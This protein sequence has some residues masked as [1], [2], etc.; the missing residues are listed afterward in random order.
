VKLNELNLNQMFGDYGAAAMKQAGN[1]LTGKAE[2]NLSVQ[3]KIAKDKFISDFIGRA[4]T[5]LNSAI[6]SGLV[7]PNIKADAAGAVEPQQDATPE[8]SADTTPQQPATST[9]PKTPAEIQKEKLAAAAKVAQDQ[10]ANSPAP[11]KPSAPT[12]P[13]SPEQTR[14]EKQ[15]AA[16][17]TAQ[18]QMAASPAPTQQTKMTPQQT[19]AL[20]GRLKAGAAPTSGQSGFKNYVGGS[21]QVQRESRY[22]KLD[23]I[24]ES[25]INIDEAQE[26]QSISEYLQNMFNQ[27]LGVPITDPKAKTQI[28]TLADQAQ[29]SYPKM[30]NALTQMAN[31]GFAISYSQGSGET[32]GAN[33]GA[34]TAQPTSGASAFSQGM[35]QGLGSSDSETSPSASTPTSASASA[36]TG[37]A[38]DQVMA[39]VDKLST[40]EKQKLIATLQEPATGGQGAFDQMKNQLQEPKTTANPVNRQQKLNVNKI[41]SGNKG[42]PTPDEE[43]KLQQR[44]Q[45]Q[46]AA[47]A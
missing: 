18:S 23:Y 31:L 34:T 38:Y 3:D 45:Q 16:T 43:A 8:P 4:S 47:Q 20:K 22:A 17:Q 29:A 11:A 35:K 6:Q 46:L 5:N 33:V 7:D 15:A 32:Q 10:M 12:A 44:I 37:S 9:A 1:R 36:Q 26:A 42:A 2:G 21:G 13:K 39:L 24:L 14:Q 27:Y 40:E 19:A 28:K 41:K 30:T 25:I